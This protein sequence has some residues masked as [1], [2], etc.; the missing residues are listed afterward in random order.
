MPTR[1]PVVKAMASSPAASSVASRRAG[2]LSG[3]PRWQSRS[4]L[5]D[6]TIIPWL[7]ETRRS[8]ASSSACSAPAFE[9]GS[10]PVSAST[11]SQQAAR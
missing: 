5:S 7:T 11:S 9:C 6:S 8:W 3:E 1:M 10:S 4:S 2:V